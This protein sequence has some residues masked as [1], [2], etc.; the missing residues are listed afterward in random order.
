MKGETLDL[1]N[2]DKP[3]PITSVFMVVESVSLTKNKTIHVIRFPVP[4]SYVNIGR[5]QDAD[6]RISDISV[7]R[8]HSV[9]RFNKNYEITLEDS[10]S[11]FGT[12]VS[13]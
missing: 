2:F 11:K 13:L 4:G 5:S 6:M 3:D 12:L 1:L 9:I 10:G 7:S 8:L